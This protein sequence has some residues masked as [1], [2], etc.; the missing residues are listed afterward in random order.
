MG[1]AQGAV[2]AEQLAS[3]DQWLLRHEWVRPF[4]G[5]VFEM[6]G[7]SNMSPAPVRYGFYAGDTRT[8]LHCSC[9]RVDRISL[10]SRS[11]H[12]MVTPISL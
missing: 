4:A 11:S 3:L 12:R 10:W 1:K 5:P 2:V 6:I 9:R 8:T 7:L